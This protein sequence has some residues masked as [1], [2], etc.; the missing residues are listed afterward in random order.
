MKMLYNIPA[1][2]H[3][4]ALI[5]GDLHLGL[6]EKLEKKGLVGIEISKKIVGWLLELIENTNTREL[7]VVGDIKER[8]GG[9]DPRTKREI[10][11]MMDVVNL[12]VVKGNHDGGIEKIDG[13]N[14]IGSGG[15]LFHG[16]GIHHGHAWPAEEVMRGKLIVSAHQHQQVEL[17][18]NFGGHREDVWIFCE[19][20]KNVKKRYPSYRGGKFLMMPVFNPF[21]GSV[22]NSEYLLGPLLKN[23]YAD[24]KN[25]DVYRLNGEYIG[26]FL[27]DKL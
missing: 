2:V 25:G 23:G 20:N 13:I 6:E 1:F 27:C 24:V 9:V 15:F 7:I 5:V 16:I 18:D 10:K 11:R 22:L 8:V 21:I 14:V 26:K 19:F 12:T 4:G 17:K 3:R